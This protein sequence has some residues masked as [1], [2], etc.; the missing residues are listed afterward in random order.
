SAIIPNSDR[1][2]KG[3]YPFFNNKDFIFYEYESPDQILENYKKELK[4]GDE[5]QILTPV[6][7]SETGTINL[8]KLIQD[9]INP[10]HPIK[11]QVVFG[12]KTFRI[13]D[14]VMQHQNNYDKEI[15]NG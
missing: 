9:N 14:R 7:R 11:P 10:E 6:K 4:T 12:D 15:F 2:N 13:G 1:I 3:L 8:N 5:D